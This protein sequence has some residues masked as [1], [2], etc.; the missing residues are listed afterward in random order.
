M[1]IRCDDK[2]DAMLGLN[3]DHSDS[4]WQDLDYYFYCHPLQRAGNGG[5]G[6]LVYYSD[7]S[8]GPEDVNLGVYTKDDVFQIY[9]NAAG[10]L[11]YTMNGEIVRARA[12]P[13]SL[14]I[15][16]RV[17]SDSQNVDTADGRLL[18][19]R[20]TSGAHI[21]HRANAAAVHGRCNVGGRDDVWPAEHPIHAQVGFSI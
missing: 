20:A 12:R 3:A 8:T 5:T 18:A 7:P 17:G 6:T 2:A 19:Q 4:S 11:E 21:G 16:L 15:I 10:K 1:W 9:L 14:C 13:H